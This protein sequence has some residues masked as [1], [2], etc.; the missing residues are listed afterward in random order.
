MFTNGVIFLLGA[1]VACVLSSRHLLAVPG[2]TPSTLEKKC[3]H[4]LPFLS[5]LCGG[6]SQPSACTPAKLAS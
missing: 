3:A 5:L 1:R 4:N 6:D 2:R